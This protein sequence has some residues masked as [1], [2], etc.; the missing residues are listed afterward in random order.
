MH[1]Q[2]SPCVINVRDSSLCL[3][4]LRA[5]AQKILVPRMND[6]VSYQMTEL[7]ETPDMY[8]C[9]GTPGTLGQ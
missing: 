3:S 8:Q 5:N 7:R 6:L 2:S 1:F 4:D 9:E